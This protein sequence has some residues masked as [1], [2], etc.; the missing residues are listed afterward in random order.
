M[1]K[2]NDLTAYQNPSQNVLGG[3]ED[4]MPKRRLRT[5]KPAKEKRDH[6]VLLSFT[7]TEIEKI[8]AEA[9]LVPVATW[10]VA[11]LREGGAID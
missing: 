10:I 7:A 8:K 4:D 11:K 2:K 9:G 6:K 5:T 3:V 1:V